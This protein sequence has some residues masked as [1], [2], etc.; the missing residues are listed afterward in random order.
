MQLHEAIAILYNALEKD[1]ARRKDG[2]LSQ[3]E[4][5]IH[6]DFDDRTSFE[7]KVTQVPSVQQDPPKHPYLR[8][9]QCRHGYLYAIDARN[10]KIG[11]YA[12][13]SAVLPGA[14]YVH[15]FW[16][17]RYK[18]GDH[19]LD[20]EF[21]RDDGDLYGTVQPYRELEKVPDDVFNGT[22]TSYWLYLAAK[23]EEYCGQQH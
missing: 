16:I 17:R 5:V 10:A 3:S 14:V 21:H 22:S 11:I 9:D 6:I 13:L 18:F 4:G 12:D 20:K 1:L 7:V 23:T 19:F 15:S 8:I 2:L